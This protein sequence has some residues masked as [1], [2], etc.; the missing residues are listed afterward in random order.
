MTE[1]KPVSVSFAHTRADLRAGNPLYDKTDPARDAFRA[2]HDASRAERRESFMVKRAQVIQKMKARVEAGF[3]VFRAPVGYK[4]ERASTG[5]KVLVPDEPLASVVKD[6]LE[7]YASGR[8]ASQAEVQ[9]FLEADPHF[10][11]DRP[12]GSLRAM[13]VW[14]LL[15]KVVYAGHVEAHKWGVSVRQGE[16]EGL[17]SFATFER[18]QD[19]LEGKRRPAARKDFNEDFPVRGFV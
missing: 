11:K 4:F 12:D 8:L 9:R 1:A 19:L 17:I 7:G 2:T 18:I 15:R 16:H 10:P 3:W 13:T 14:R 5:G 6:A